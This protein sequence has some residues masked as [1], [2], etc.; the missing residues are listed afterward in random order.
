M[1][2]RNASSANVTTGEEAQMFSL[3]A[4]HFKLS[5][6]I[7]SIIVF[8]TIFYGLNMNCAISSEINIKI[9]TTTKHG[10]QAQCMTLF[11]QSKTLKQ[12]YGIFD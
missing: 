11:S 4:L 1:E 3:H 10:L 12:H 9:A 6:I 7:V 8:E 2:A 5:I